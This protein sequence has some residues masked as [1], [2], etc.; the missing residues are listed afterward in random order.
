[1]KI[2]KRE[3]MFIEKKNQ[4]VSEP[5][6]FKLMLFKDQLYVDLLQETD[7]QLC[8]WLSKSTGKESTCNKGYTRDMGSIPGSERSPGGGKWQLCSCILFLY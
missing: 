4:C 2:L 5:T 8:S 1:M 3:E 6:Q 7:M